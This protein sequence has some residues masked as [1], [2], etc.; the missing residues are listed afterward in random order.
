MH[1]A[2]LY[3]LSFLIWAVNVSFQNHLERDCALEVPAMRTG[4]NVLLL[5]LLC[6][7]FTAE[8]AYARAKVPPDI[9]RGLVAHYDFSK[10]EGRAA[11]N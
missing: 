7:P 10:M 3:E 1:A 6:L 9:Q 11:F 5:G 8:L 2:G 4:N